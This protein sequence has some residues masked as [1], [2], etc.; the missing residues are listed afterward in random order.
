LRPTVVVTSVFV[1]GEWHP[2]A[3]TK[4]CHFDSDRVLEHDW[5]TDIDYLCDCC[6]LVFIKQMKL[7]DILPQAN[8]YWIGASA[9]VQ[10]VPVGDGLGEFVVGFWALEEAAD[11]AVQ[12]LHW[13]EDDEYGTLRWQACDWLFESRAKGQDGGFIFEDIFFIA[14][15]IHEQ[16]VCKSG[17]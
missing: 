11:K 16:V 2:Q 4:I 6:I 15:D 13:T 5:L 9:S 3:G 1:S 10:H 7:Q 8:P 12:V 14:N 17:R